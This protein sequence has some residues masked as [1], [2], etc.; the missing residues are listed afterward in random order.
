MPF[1]I[2]LD[3]D[4][5]RRIER[6]AREARQSK[7]A[8]VREAIEAYEHRAVTAAASARATVFDQVAHLVGLFDSGV[9]DLSEHT[10]RRFTERLKANHR[11]RRAR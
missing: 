4:T 11:A 9:G 10:G 8:V 3:P 7:A 1:S 2:R 5:E 6:L